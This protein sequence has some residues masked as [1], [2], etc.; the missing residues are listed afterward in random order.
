MFNKEKRK[1]KK[2]FLTRLPHK[3]KILSQCVNTAFAGALL[4]SISV[5][6]NA[7]ANNV[8][9]GAKQPKFIYLALGAAH[10]PYHVPQSY[11]QSYSGKYD[12]GWDQLRLDRF[13]KQKKLGVIPKN[14][15]LP[16]REK[17]DVAMGFIRC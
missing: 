13:D 17:G 16:P 7:A 9:A 1:T 8:V 6:T 4:L 2:W 3:H 14:T 10:S 11:I 15:I 5:T 12:Q